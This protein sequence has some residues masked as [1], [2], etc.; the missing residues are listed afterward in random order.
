[1]LLLEKEV[2]LLYNTN[3]FNDER[4]ENMKGIRIITDSTSDLT[5]ELYEKLDIE[6]IPLTVSIGGKSYADGKDIN[7][8]CSTIWLKSTE[9]FRKLPLSR[10]EL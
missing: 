4:E 8:K 10:R 2:I 7:P 1:M 5:P 9:S 3:I 6:V